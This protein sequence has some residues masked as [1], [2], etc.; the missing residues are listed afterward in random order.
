MK[1]I[2]VYNSDN[3]NLNEFIQNEELFVN[4]KNKYLVYKNDLGWY[5]HTK[6]E[7]IDYA[8]NLIDANPEL[9]PNQKMVNSIEDSV[10]I[11]EN[12]LDNER[13][14]EFKGKF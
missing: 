12:T 5:L 13:V 3:V 2:E 14:I 4:M 6:E 10:Y 8:N 1:T 11:I 9:Y 7:V